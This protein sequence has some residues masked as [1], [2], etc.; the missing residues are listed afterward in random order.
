MPAGHPA[1]QLGGRA[2]Q[3]RLEGR[4]VLVL[5]GLLR[6]EYVGDH[7]RDV[8][9]RAGLQAGPDQLDGRVVGAAHREDVGDPAVG[10]HPARA[11]TA[12][13]Q[14]VAGDQLEHE[15]VG[16]GV[17]DAVEGL[18]DQVAV[19]V[20]PRLLLG[21][22][23][24]VDEALHERVV[25]GE[26]RDLALAEQVGAAVADMPDRGPGSVEEG[27]GGGGAG[28]VERGVLVDQRAD[29]AVG[30]VECVGDPRELVGALGRGLV[31]PAQLRDRRR[32]GDVT[33]RRATD[34][35]ADAEQPGTGVPGVL[36][37]LA[38]PPHVGDRGVRK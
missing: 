34:T 16:L 26:L 8:V 22:P 27:H 7:A 30:I 31:E 3:H 24:L 33:A 19:R 12:E 6:G 4:E 32:G 17:V 36:V 18:E 10:E 14:P 20:D 21:D 9:G 11:V 23:A 5:G 35:V 28:A 2:D 38:D 37:V 25:G 13:E 29:R 1:L 15:Q